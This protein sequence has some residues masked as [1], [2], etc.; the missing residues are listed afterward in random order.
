MNSINIIGRLTEDPQR[1]PADTLGVSMR[2][3]FDQKDEAG[4]VDVALWERNAQACL[5]YLH[6]G[7][8]IAVSGRLTYRSWENG[9]GARRSALGIS[10]TRVDFLRKGKQAAA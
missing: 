9:E 4:Y 10:A 5:E 6:K 8:E 1:I 2:L 3:A 7:A